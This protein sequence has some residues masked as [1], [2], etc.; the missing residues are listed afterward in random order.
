MT[1]WATAEYD[2]PDPT[3]NVIIGSNS[4]DELK[5]ATLESGGLFAKFAPRQVSNGYSPFGVAVM[6]VDLN[7][8]R[9]IRD[10]IIAAVKRIEANSD[11]S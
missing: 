9:T 3:G 10:Q 6:S 7:G 11:P 1:S 5:G 4:N 8:A 2:G